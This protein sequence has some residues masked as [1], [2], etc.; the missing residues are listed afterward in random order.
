MKNIKNYNRKI[1]LYLKSNL[2][3]LNFYVNLFNFLTVFYYFQ[4][5][6]TVK[7]NNNFIISL[8]NVLGVLYYVV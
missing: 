3:G 5:Y 7:S 4:I 6:T 1:F 2:K 8:Y